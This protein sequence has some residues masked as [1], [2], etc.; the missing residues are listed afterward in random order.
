MAQREFK[1][2]HDWLGKKIHWEVC[3][4]YGFDVKRKWYEHEPET[5]MENDISTILRDFNINTDHVIQARGPDLVINDKLKNQCL[6]VEFAIPSDSRIET[7]EYEKLDKYQDLARELKK[8]W[9]M[10]LQVIPIIIG[11]LGTIPKDLHQR[12]KEIGIETKIVELQKTVILNSA[13]I[14]RKVLEF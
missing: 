3:L 13:R 12:L 4:K 9:N 10:N 5:A 14:L 7:K 2:R 11:A 1:R 6:I 8:L